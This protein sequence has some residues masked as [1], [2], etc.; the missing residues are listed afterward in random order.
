MSRRNTGAGLLRSALDSRVP[1]SSGRRSRRDTPRSSRSLRASQAA[2][3]DVSD[4]DFDD[5][6]SIASD[7]TWLLD[8]DE[9]ELVQEVGDNWEDLLKASLESLNEKRASVREKTLEGIIRLMSHV[10]I[11]DGLEG[12]RVTLLEALQRGTRSSK[13]AR[14]QQLSLQ[15]IGLWFINFGTGDE[16]EEEFE[17]VDRQLRK[18]L[19]EP[20]VDAQVQAQAVSTLAIANFISSADYRD[21]VGLQQFIRGILEDALQERQM[22]VALQGFS[23]I[24]LLLTVLANSDITLAEHQFDED[25]ELHMRGLKCDSVEVRVA[26]AQN[27]AMMHEALSQDRKPFAFDNQYELVG[28]LE[29]LKHESNKRLGRRL[30]VKQRLAMRDV[31]NTIEDGQ[32]PTLKLTLFNRTLL[33]DDWVCISRLQA[34]RAALGGGL[35]EHLANNGLLQDVFEIELDAPEDT[36]HSK[37]RV[38]VGPSSDLAKLRTLDMR[39]RRDER[40]QAMHAEVED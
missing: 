22:E 13:S 3:R 1:S 14:E 9:R 16:A 33:F 11:G 10:Y 36:A 20:E 12:H 21:A 30:S 34:F 24:G 4:D 17:S 35:P 25:Y 2:S 38:V 19:E 28:V 40:H 37:R 39:R 26:A 31:L 27:I 5:T 23:A 18:L 7:S 6:A 15:A 32:A 29:M 8:E